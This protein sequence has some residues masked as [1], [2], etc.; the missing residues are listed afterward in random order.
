MAD[1]LR[2]DYK[3]DILNTE[4]NTQRKYRMVQND[5]GTVSFEDVTKYSQ[6]GDSFG[7]A[8]INKTN[9]A[10]SELNRALVAKGN[11][12]L[13]CEVKNNYGTPG[14]NVSLSDDISNYKNII[15][16]CK[17]SSTVANTN[18]VIVPVDLLNTGGSFGSGFFE[19]YACFVTKVD[20]RTV[21]LRSAGTAAAIHI[22]NIYG[23]K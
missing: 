17:T 23:V 14:S 8:D 21:L 1:L 2:T 16:T 10:V 7:A 15:I 11:L 9:E 6:V 3:D 18:V 4:V 19:N 12:T 20:E 5:D 13:L 22:V